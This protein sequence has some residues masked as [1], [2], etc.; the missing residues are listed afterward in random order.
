MSPTLLNRK[1]SQH[2]LGDNELA[3]GLRTAID[4]K[5]GRIFQAARREWERTFAGRDPSDACVSVRISGGNGRRSLLS[6]S[7]HLGY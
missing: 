4:G 5:Y 6:G 3:A 1:A 7:Y 2:R